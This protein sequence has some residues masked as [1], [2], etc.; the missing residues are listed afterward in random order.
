MN[1]PQPPPDVSPAPVLDLLWAF[2]RSKTMFAAVQFGIFDELQ[3]K[4]QDA[5]ELAKTLELNP[6][7]LRRL[8]D[9]CVSLGLL[10]HSASGYRN[11]PVSA[12][13]LTSDSPDTLSK[14]V[15]YSNQSLLRLWTHLED[16]V[17]EGS[18]RWAQV[19]GSRDA[20]FDQ[21]F[22]DDAAAATFLGGMHEFGQ[23]ASPLI[24]RAFDLSRFTH[25][26]DLGGASGHVAVA[27]CETYPALRATV[28]DLP[29]V[30]S[31]A[32]QHIAQSGVADRI[33]FVP[34]DF[35][36]G[37]LPRGDLYNLGRILHDWPEEK[38]MSLVQKIHTAL[39]SGGALLIEE[40][41]IDEDRSGP[42]YTLMQDLNM[43]VCTDGKERTFSEYREL[44]ERSGFQWVDARR[45][46]SLVDAILAVKD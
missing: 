6:A 3:K 1:L 12:R 18:N 16:A 35:F 2:R 37:D 20:L 14:Y 19:F 8:L 29:G 46:G 43:L 38:I 39:P 15:Q 34:G 11:T 5:Q 40:T 41:L 30:E 4:V 31:F 32:M 42:V 13:Y 26:V 33:Q 45:T 9:G 27:A 25:L 22:R 23:I 21:F 36:V 28:L 10:E 7:A 17:R 24:V 44:L